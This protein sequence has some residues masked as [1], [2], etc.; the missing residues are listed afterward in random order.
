MLENVQTLQEN[1]IASLQVILS[2]EQD[3]LILEDALD[4]LS[5]EIDAICN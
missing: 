3:G 1:D 4:E 2:N 5:I